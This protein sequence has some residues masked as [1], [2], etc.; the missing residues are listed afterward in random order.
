MPTTKTPRAPRASFA[1]PQDPPSAGAIT[2]A[3]IERVLLRA[4]QAAPD[5]APDSANARHVQLQDAVRVNLHCYREDLEYGPGSISAVLS[6]AYD[7]LHDCDMVNT[8]P[9]PLA[10]HRNLAALVDCARLATDYVAYR[11]DT[12]L[13]VLD[14]ETE[15]PK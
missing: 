13:K 1:T 7:L 8:Q 5:P 11:I 10:S 12:M 4:A 3:D 14:A 6:L 15:G 2:P 9:S